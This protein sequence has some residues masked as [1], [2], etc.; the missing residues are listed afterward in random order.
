MELVLIILLPLLFAVLALG[1]CR[2]GQ[3]PLR[4]LQLGAVCHLLL[5]CY[6]TLPG[7]AP[8][9]VSFHGID[10]FGLDH[11]SRLLLTLTSLLFA[12]VAA[13][14]ARWYP[15]DRLLGKKRGHGHSLR[16][17]L[18]VACMLSFLSMMSMVLVARNLGVL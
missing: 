13:H 5:V 3:W 16:P 7:R 12:C 1:L 10:L 4:L 8:D 18:F 15:A 17:G 11:V 6:V 14:S 9:L 2:H